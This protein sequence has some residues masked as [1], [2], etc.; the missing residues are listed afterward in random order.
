[1]RTWTLRLRKTD[2]EIFDQIKKG[3]KP[4]ETRAATVRYVPIENGDT[5][6]FVC[7]DKRCSKKIKRKTHFKNVDSLFKKIPF[8]KILPSSKSV[9]EAKK[10]YGSFSGYG[11]KI[12]KF[13]IF[14]FELESGR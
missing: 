2:T 6:I 10:V 1:M 12:K 3:T 9:G 11:E 7:G 14:A 13:G 4:V 8:N 5:L